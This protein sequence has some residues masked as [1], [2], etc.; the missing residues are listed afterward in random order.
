MFAFRNAGRCA[1]ASR[2][3]DPGP[4]I[5]RHGLDDRLPDRDDGVAFRRQSRLGGHPQALTTRCWAH[6]VAPETRRQA[7]GAPCNIASAP[8]PLQR[9]P[10][11][12]LPCRRGPGPSGTDAR[13]PAPVRG[14]GF[15]E[16][17]APPR[18]SPDWPGV[19]GRSGSPG[20]SRTRLRRRSARLSPGSRIRSR[21]VAGAANRSGRIRRTHRARPKESP[22]CFTRRWL[23]VAPG[24]LCRLDG[25]LQW[26]PFMLVA[27]SRSGA[28]D[29][30]PAAP[31]HVLC[32]L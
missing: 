18:R 5:R 6:P 17:H 13:G 1:P 30:T 27:R 11:R 12:R 3:S 29:G 23:Q 16:I 4:A 26:R 2:V 24:G 25:A 21:R 28:V 22:V 8:D 10:H 19:P 15:A 7:R 20:T 9:V 31:Q 32:Q 14:H